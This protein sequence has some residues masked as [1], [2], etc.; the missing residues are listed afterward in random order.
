MFLIVDFVSSLILV[1]RRGDGDTEG[2]KVP[3]S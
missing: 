1:G 3:P 2:S